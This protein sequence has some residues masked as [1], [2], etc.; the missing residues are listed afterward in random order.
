MKRTSFIAIIL[1]SLFTLL[2]SG[3]SKQTAWQSEISSISKE[4]KYVVLYIDD[5]SSKDSAAI[6]DNLKENVNS[7]PEQ[8]K[9]IEINYSKE[10]DALLKYLN[11]TS[12]S[13]FPLALTIAPNGAITG[14]V[15]QKCTND[16]LKAMVVEKKESETLLSLQKG[17]VVLLCIH[18]GQSEDLTRV[19][20][21][22]KAI[23]TNFNGIVVAQYADSEDKNDMNFIKKLPETSANIT[24]FTVV[25]PGS[26]KAKLEGDQINNKNLLS[27]I[28]SSCSSGSCGPSGCN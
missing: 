16:E 20:S 28:Q 17:N 15:A 2:I 25:P 7:M 3:C 26:I 22:L 14:S 4:N 9:F 27:M 18:K 19:K 11:T 1:I 24:V 12:I 6:R 13:K 21:E 10:K 5:G 23:E 8:F